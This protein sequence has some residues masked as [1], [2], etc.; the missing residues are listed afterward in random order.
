MGCNCGKQKS[1][2]VRTPDGKVKSLPSRREA[3]ALA[4]VTKDASVVEVRK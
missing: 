1:Y 3:N 2:E 4:S